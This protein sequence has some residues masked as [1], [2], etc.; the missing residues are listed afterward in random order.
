MGVGDIF[1]M[2]FPLFAI[3][4]LLGGAW[5]FINK[6]KV[7]SNLSKFN[8]L[9]IDVVSVKSIMPKKYIAV[10]KVEDKLLVLGISDNAVNLLQ[11]KDFDE[12]YLRKEEIPNFKSK[13]QEILKSNWP[14]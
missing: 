9:P 14:R 4:I 3:V 10:V 12:S 2:I 1:Q 8:T 5:Y 6:K 13:F 11:E 7:I